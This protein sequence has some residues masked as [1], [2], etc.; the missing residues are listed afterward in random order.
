[1]SDLSYKN[2][3]GSIPNEENQPRKTFFS[4][5]WSLEYFRF[6]VKLMYKTG[7]L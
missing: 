6:S 4:L 7:Q 3:L 1:M 2:P 5:F